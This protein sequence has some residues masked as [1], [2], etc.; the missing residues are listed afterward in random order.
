MQLLKDAYLGVIA[1]NAQ[2]L[3]GEQRAGRRLTDSCEHPGPTWPLR[4]PAPAVLEGLPG[5]VRQEPQ[6]TS[7]S[8]C[9]E[10]GEQREEV[11]DRLLSSIIAERGRGDRRVIIDKAQDLRA[12]Q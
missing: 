6:H 8:E 3:G 4:R 11:H 7:G 10:H 9:A 1:D 5:D 2:D 12:T